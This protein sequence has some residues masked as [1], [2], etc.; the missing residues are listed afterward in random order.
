[1]AKNNEEMF[2]KCTAGGLGFI[3]G[4]LYQVLDDENAV[5]VAC[6]EKPIALYGYGEYLGLRQWADT[7]KFEDGPRF[8]RVSTQVAALTLYEKS[9]K[10]EIEKRMEQWDAAMQECKKK[11]VGSYSMICQGKYAGY[12]K[13]TFYY[14]APNGMDFFA[15]ALNK[16]GEQ[17]ADML[18][19]V[20]G[21]PCKFY[22]L[23]AGENPHDNHTKEK[24]NDD[25][26]ERLLHKIVQR[27]MIIEEKVGIDYA[28]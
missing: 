26:T 27:L 20:V 5:W 17:L 12:L 7:G 15:T 21:E 4:N 13:N 16:R 6:S 19:K 25:T 1:M 8:V 11:D 9:V 28:E 14:L 22:A 18:S 24:P 2:V 23:K 10:T 3:E